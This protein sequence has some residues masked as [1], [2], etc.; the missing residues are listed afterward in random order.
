MCG[1]TGLCVNC[2]KVTSG[3]HQ[4]PGRDIVPPR[5]IERYRHLRDTDTR[6][7]TYKGWLKSDKLKSELIL[8]GFFYLGEKD[9][10]QCAYCGGVLHGFEEDD[11]VHIEHYRHFPRCETF[12]KTDSETETFLFGHVTSTH[13]NETQTDG[14]TCTSGVGDINSALLEKIKNLDLS[15]NTKCPRHKYYA[16]YKDRL[17]TFDSPKWPANHPMKKETLAKAGLFYAGVGDLCEC[18]CCG[19]QLEEFEEGDVPVEEHDKYFSDICVLAI[20]RKLQGES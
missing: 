12:D 6:T 13:L 10:V 18:Y 17:R 14:A 16:Q 5:P 11:N 3:M 8:D 20:N 4:V 2:K 1:I 15:T 9:R 7:R 19:G